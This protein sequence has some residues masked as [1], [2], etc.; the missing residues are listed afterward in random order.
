MYIIQFQSMLNALIRNVNFVYFSR[1]VMCCSKQIKIYCCVLHIY[2]LIIHLHIGMNILDADRLVYYKFG[3]YGLTGLLTIINKKNIS[4]VEDFVMSCRVTGR[5]VEEEIVNFLKK[6]YQKKNNKIILNLKK[7]I[8][9]DLM[10]NFL[11]N[12]KLFNRVKK[13]EYVII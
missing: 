4:F 1:L 9:N 3:Y 13:G 2:H 8:K 5:G 6:K 7:T 11:E 12:R 10:Q